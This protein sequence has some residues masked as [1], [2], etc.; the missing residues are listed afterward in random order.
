[1]HMSMASIEIAFIVA[2][3]QTK[4][5]CKYTCVCCVIA[6]A[7]PLVSALQRARSDG[8]TTI[9]LLLKLVGRTSCATTAHSR[10]AQQCYTSI[11]YVAS[12]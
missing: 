11:H 4:L 5:Q 6:S 2:L 10:P 1:M 8:V 12:R 9:V 7:L 3:R